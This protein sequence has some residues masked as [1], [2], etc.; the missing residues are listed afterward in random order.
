M[1]HGA[2]RTT[3]PNATNPLWITSIVTDP[4]DPGGVGT[5]VLYREKIGEEKWQ[6]WSRV[7]FNAA[8]ITNH[9]SDLV[10][11]REDRT[12]WAWFFSSP[13]GQRFTYGPEL[14][15][16]QR[17]LAVAGDRKTLWA[18]ALPSAKSTQPVATRP[19]TTPATRTVNPILYQLKGNQWTPHDAPLPAGVYFET[20]DQVSMMIINESPTLAIYTG[21]LKIQLV[22]YSPAARRWERHREGAVTTGPKAP[23]WFKLLNLAEQ[24]AV[25]VWGDVEG[26]LGNIWT[27]T[28]SIELPINP[29][30][31]LGEAD[32]TAAGDTIWLVYRNKQGKLYQQRFN[33]DGSRDDQPTGAVASGPERR[34]RQ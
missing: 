22:Q 31:G 30:I 16:R 15:D 13:T 27:P 2:G 34:R 9:S 29:E 8:D 21:D 11:V 17:M 20:P 28:G 23:Q 18:L 24:P 32:V 4:K 5:M 19:T 6:E 14:P 7:G 10:M 33:R 26:T 25:W 3:G 12:K 1:I